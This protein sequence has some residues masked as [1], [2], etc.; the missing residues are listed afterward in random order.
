MHKIIPNLKKA[1]PELL[2]HGLKN[3]EIGN[4]K[5]DKVSIANKTKDIIKV[6]LR[7]SLTT[8]ISILLI[9]YIYSFLR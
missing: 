8:I 5:I 1:K 9:N 4:N 3:C 2:Q 6:V 7:D